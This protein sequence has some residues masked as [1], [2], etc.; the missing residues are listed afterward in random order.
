MR[1]TTSRRITRCSRTIGPL[2]LA[3]VGCAPAPTE[4]DQLLACHDK[5][6]GGPSLRAL[7]AVEYDLEIT[8]PTFSVQGHYRATRAGTMRIDIVAG[9]K[10]VFSEGFDHGAGWQMEADSTRRT[11]VSADGSAALR[12]GIEQPGHLWTLADMIP[13][14]HAVELVAPDAGDDPA[15]RILK[16]TLRDGFATWYW[17]DTTS[18]LVTKSRNFRAFHPDADSTRK[19]TE[20][21]RAGYERHDGVMRPMLEF[22]VDL[23]TGDTIGR[24][25]VVSVRGHRA[26]R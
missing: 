18:C 11:P 20:T 22:N 25:R 12:H 23:L 15:S 2:V 21:H 16:V 8:E 3:L 5:A 1:P 9:G 6:V 7:T 26:D 19:W 14:G 13:N 17:V 4:L 24:G 10:R